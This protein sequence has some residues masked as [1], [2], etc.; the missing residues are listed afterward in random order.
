MRDT[1]ILEERNKKI[2]ERYDYFIKI[3]RIQTDFALEKLRK[4]FYLAKRTI[5]NILTT[6]KNG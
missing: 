4:E 5:Y 3:E 6:E 2:R 1:E